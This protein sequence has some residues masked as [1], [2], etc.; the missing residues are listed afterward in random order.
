VRVG[1]EEGLRYVYGGNVSG[2][3]SESTYC[4]GCGDLLLERRG[5]QVGR[6]SIAGGRCPRCGQE[7]AIR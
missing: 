7:I 6:Q 2:H 4:P 5:Y 1:R 3:S